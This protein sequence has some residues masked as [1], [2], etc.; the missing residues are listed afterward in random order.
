MI[1]DITPER[2]NL[3]FLYKDDRLSYFM[4]PET[5][6][7]VVIENSR[8]GR[9]AGFLIEAITVPVEF[10]DAQPI[11]IVFPDSVEVKVADTAAAAHGVTNVWKHATLENGLEILVPPFIARGET[12]RIDVER[13]T[14]ME[15]PRKK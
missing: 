5:F 3:Q 9:A 11:G 15:R 1:E 14:Y 10:V 2:Q 6:E 13:G 7:Q 4:H 8:L 12:I